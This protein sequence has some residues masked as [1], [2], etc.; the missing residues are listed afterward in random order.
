MWG[1]DEQRFGVLKTAFLSRDPLPTMNQTFS[2]VQK[3]ETMKMTTCKKEQIGEVVSFAVGTSQSQPRADEMSRDLVC[4]NCGQ[5]DHK[6]DMCYQLIGYPENWG[7][8]GPINLEN[9][10]GFDFGRHSDNRGGYC[11]RGR[12]RNFSSPRANI[13]HENGDNFFKFSGGFS[14]EELKMLQMMINT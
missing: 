11:G 7:E 13:S 1:L 10:N 5:I 8:R 12:G 6:K 9:R 14:E 2:T 4:S 3:E